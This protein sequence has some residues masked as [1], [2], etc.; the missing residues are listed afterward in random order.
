MEREVFVYADLQGTPH[1]VGRLWPRV[2]NERESA[3]FDFGTRE[4]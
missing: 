4:K 2:R 3:S 1:L